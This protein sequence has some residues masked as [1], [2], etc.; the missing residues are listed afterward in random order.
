MC[1]VG[2]LAVEYAPERGK[3]GVFCFG[4]LVPLKGRILFTI[5]ST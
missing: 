5:E 1:H 2:V 4:T 3:R